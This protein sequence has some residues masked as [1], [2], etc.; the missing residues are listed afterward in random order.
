MLDHSQ[1]WS[2]NDWNVWMESHFKAM[3]SQLFWW[4]YELEF[5]WQ[6]SLTWND[7]MIMYDP[8][9]IKHIKHQSEPFMS[10]WSTLVSR[11]PPIAYF[12]QRAGRYRLPQQRFTIRPAAQVHLCPGFFCHMDDW[13]PFYIATTSRCLN[14][15]MDAEAHTCDWSQFSWTKLEFSRF[16]FAKCILFKKRRQTWQ[17]T[18]KINSWELRPDLYLVHRKGFAVTVKSSRAVALQGFL[19]TLPSR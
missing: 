19:V 9:R 17:T 13:C 1:H 8:L 10:S 4:L 16:G 14:S 15:G 6:K 2:C 11:F 12:L 5:S 7:C 18:C 3:A